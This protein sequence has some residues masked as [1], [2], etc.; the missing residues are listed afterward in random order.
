[1]G[2]PGLFIYWLRNFPEFIT[3]Y[4]QGE[5]IFLIDNFFL[6]TNPIIHAEAQHVFG[7][8]EPD[9]FN[10]YEELSYLQKKEVV[11]E[12]VFLSIQELFVSVV[13]K[14]LLYIAI[15]GVGPLA[16]ISQQ[17][18]RRLRSSLGKELTD[19]TFDAASI[20]PG[21]LFMQE[22]SIEI[23][24]RIKERMTRD[25]AWKQIKVIYSSHCVPGE[26]EHKLLEYIRKHPELNNETNLIWSPD[27]DLI[28]L[29]LSLHMKNVFVM[30]RGDSSHYKFNKEKNEF[31][32]DNANTSSSLYRCLNQNIIINISASEDDLV[33]RI[34]PGT[35]NKGLLIDDFVFL[36]FFLGNDFLP[37]IEMIQYLAN[38][39]EIIIGLYRS[40]RLTTSKYIVH[41]EN[42]PASHAETVPVSEGYNFPLFQ[43]FVEKLAEMEPDEL[44]KREEN[45]DPAFENKTLKKNLTILDVKGKKQVKLNFQGY[46]KDYY[47]KAGI[48]DIRKVCLEYLRMFIWTHIYYTRGIPSWSIQYEYLYAPMMIDLASVLKTLTEEE[49]VYLVTFEK[50]EPVNTV[51]QLL[52]ILPRKSY[53][54]LNEKLWPLILDVGSPLEKIYLKEEEIVIDREGKKRDHEA[55]VLLPVVSTSFVSSVLNEYLEK[56]G[57][58]I[59]DVSFCALDAKTLNFAVR[60]E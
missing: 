47:E 23:V 36:G 4:N 17:R 29:S 40:I 20:S 43:K 46:R 52:T 27:N 49:K 5:R 56:M 2:V 55:I 21:T 6:D 1:M 37:K 35:S 32:C 13:P 54:L 44:A 30:K 9:P 57:Y 12:R 38:G 48:K 25:P 41:S 53:R 50:S 15:D 11:V 10:I 22:I 16:K 24:K 60:R 31:E 8:G 34:E 39:I 45:P 51:V 59:T 7:Y 58:L 26:G 42:D 28:D 3:I 33:K 14:H 18:T 19:L